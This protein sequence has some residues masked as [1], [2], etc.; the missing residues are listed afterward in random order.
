MKM[1]YDFD[2]IIEREESYSLKWDERQKRF[3]RADV[4][5]MWVADMDFRVSEPVRQVCIRRAEH[6]IFGY[7]SKPASYFDAA[8]EFE[9]RRHGWDIERKSLGFALGIVPAIAEL[10]REFTDEGDSILIQTPAYSQIYHII[11]SCRGRKVMENPLV[12]EEG[13]YTMDFADLEEK[14]KKGPKLM[15]LCNPHNP[16]GR[17]WTE[18]ELLKVHRLCLKYKVPVISDEIHG[19]L[20]LFS[21]EYT[22]SANLGE[23]IRANTVCC[24]SATKTFNLAGLQACMIV[25]HNPE[26]KKRFDSFWQG[27][28]IDRNN[29]FSL[30]AMETAWREGDD[31]LDQVR[32]Y[33][34]KNMLFAKEYIDQNLPQLKFRVPEATYLAWIDFSALGLD[35]KELER[36]LVMEAGVGLS[37][38]T[39]FGQEGTGFMRMNMATPRSNVEKALKQIKEAVDR[40]RYGIC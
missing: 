19:D 1:T 2:E 10:I 35:Q 39:E 5:P 38:G 22:P 32:D 31:W 3:G 24:F 26:W 40:G 12:N 25:F 23:E 14:L 16:V 30:V 36:F 17:I 7:T 37:S 8:I 28:D 11:E 27:I 6:G 21:N 4:I 15:I 34:G 20:T 33:I 9:K 18:E 29:C 13:Y